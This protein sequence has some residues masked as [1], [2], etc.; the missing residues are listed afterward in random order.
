MDEAHSVLQEHLTFIVAKTG[1]SDMRTTW[2][3][4]QSEE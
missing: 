4:S 3:M 2:I 1:Q